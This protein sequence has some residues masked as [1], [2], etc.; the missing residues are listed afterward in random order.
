MLSEV[1]EGDDTLASFKFTRF[2]NYKKN[3][4]NTLGQYED[5]QNLQH[6]L[7]CNQA[8]ASL[9]LGQKP[10]V[11]AKFGDVRVEAAYALAVA[12]IP[13]DR[14]DLLGLKDMIAKLTESLN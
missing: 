8:I 3:L 12:M 1:L 10:S 7:T 4:Y 2:N 9:L 5:T 6:R 11:E 13:L 14:G